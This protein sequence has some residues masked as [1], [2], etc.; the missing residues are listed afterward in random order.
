MSSITIIGL[1]NMARVLATRALAGG[2]TVEVVG[3]DAAK[4][5]ALAKEL[6]GGTT[7]GVMGSAPTGDI[8]VLAVPYASAAPIVTGYGDALDGKVIVDISNP[9]DPTRTGL[10]TPTNSSAAE[11]IAKVVPAGT[12]VVKA[13][14]T[15][16]GHVLAADRIGGRPLDV[17]IAGD[18][19]EAKLRVAS[20]IESLA[21]RPLDTGDLK[22]AHW[23]EGAGLLMMGVLFGKAVEGSNFWLGINTLG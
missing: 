23:L 15:L 2:N 4:A 7:A 16:F 5:A 9:F 12:H 20:F 17:F 11:E 13:F 14:N 8:V 1:G 6:G 3:R 21:L 10:V 19:A 22:M 18:D